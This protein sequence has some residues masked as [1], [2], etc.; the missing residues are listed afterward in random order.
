[1]H[2]VDPGACSSAL[3]GTLTHKVSPG[4]MHAQLWVR[5]HARPA[6]LCPSC[7]A[8]AI[9]SAAPGKSLLRQARFS[10]ACACWGCSWCGAAGDERKYKTIK[11]A[12]EREILQAA[13]V[14]C[15]T[16]AGAGDARLLNFRWADQ[17]EAAKKLG[18][19]QP[20]APS[21]PS[22]TRTHTLHTAVAGSGVLGSQAH[23][24]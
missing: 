10:Q 12:I 7:V 2:V 16:C 1:M 5:Q 11:K 4:H 8:G 19:W 23:L 3:A 15:C 9:W 13:D 21:P 20:T 24:Q 14:V 6:V 22:T 17:K 18:P